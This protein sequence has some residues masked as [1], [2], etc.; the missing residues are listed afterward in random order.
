MDS[1]TQIALGAA[2]GEAVMG[3]KVGWRALVWGA[4]C[5]TLP[6][7]DVFI[8]LGDAV[9]D[10]TYHRAASHS[11]FVLAA[12]TPLVVWLILRLHPQTRDHWRGW[13][14]LVYLAFAT[15]VLLD[16]FTVYGTQIFW[17]L[18]STPMTWSTVFI[19]D[20]LYTL[21]LLVGVLAALLLSRA[22]AWGRRLNAAGLVLSTLYL[23][24]SL[25]AKFTVERTAHVSL[26]AQQIPYERLLTT[27]APF[28]IVLWRVLAMTPDGYL[29]GF[30]SLLD[31]TDRLKV[32]RHESSP[33]LLAGLEENWP[34]RR[35]RW[36]TKGFYSVSRLGDAVVITDLRM[37]LDPDYVFRFKVG[38]VGNPHARP[39]T[40]TALRST[41]DPGRLRWVWERLW[42]EIDTHDEPRGSSGLSAAI[43]ST[44]DPRHAAVPGAPDGNEGAVSG[45]G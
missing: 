18:D 33:G 35:L 37:G 25:V 29:E 42:R 30:R 15:H 9:R 10:F 20:P 27:P 45:P 40:P 28:N 38:E 1:L 43:P 4:I 31:K 41:L 13:G 14:A 12:L 44:P 19:I 7:L 36:F 34:V 5:G 22:R 23:A 17:P 2:V 26:R 3:R 39:A 8:P 16:S 6:D 24:L 11:L 21:P 32:T